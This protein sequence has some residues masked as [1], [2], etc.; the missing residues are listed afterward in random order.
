MSAL[1]VLRKARVMSAA[2][3]AHV[4]RMP[5][6]SVYAELVR[7]EARGQV[8]VR[9]TGRPQFGTYSREWVALC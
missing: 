3:I 5:L 6:A 4:A 2:D 8:K 1:E 9:C 7:A